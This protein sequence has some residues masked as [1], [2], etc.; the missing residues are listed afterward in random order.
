MEAANCWVRAPPRLSALWCVRDHRTMSGRC[1]TQGTSTTSRHWVNLTIYL[2]GCRFWWSGLTACVCFNMSFLLRKV[3]DV[4]TISKQQ[5]LTLPW[6]W[7]PFCARLMYVHIFG[8]VHIDLFW[9]VYSFFF[10]MYIGLA[11]YLTKDVLY[12]QLFFVLDI[13]FFVLDIGLNW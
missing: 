3:E 2:L 6:A 11:G 12:I 1:V 7:L 8:D 5:S 9:I 10:D 4:T 13:V